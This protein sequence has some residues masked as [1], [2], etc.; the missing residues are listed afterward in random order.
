MDLKALSTAEDGRAVAELLEAF[1]DPL[2]ENLDVIAND[3]R[4]LAA[5]SP[6]AAQGVL[7]LYAAY[8]AARESAQNLA[9]KL[10]GAGGEVEQI[11]P[12]A[13]SDRRGQ[14]SDSA[15]SQLLPRART[16]RRD[17]GARGA[18]RN[19]KRCSRIWRRTSTRTRG[20]EVRIEQPAR[21]RSALRRYNPAKRILW[22]SEV[23]RRGSRNFQLAHQVGLLTQ[24]DVLDRI[25]GDPLL[26]PRSRARSRGLRS[27]TTSPARMLMP[28]DA[29]LEAR[30]G[31]ALRHR[32]ARPPLP[33]EL[34]AD[35]PPPDDAAAAR[36]GG[37]AVPHPPHRHRRQHLQALQR[38]GHPLRALQRRLPALERVRRVLT[39][40]MIRTQVS[41]LP[42]G[43]VFFESRERSGRTRR[44]P[45]APARQSAI[46]MGCDVSLRA[47]RW[48][49]RT[50]STWRTATPSCRSAHLPA[51][52]AHGLRAAGAPAD[53]ACPDGQRARRGVSFY[54]PVAECDEP[55]H[56]R[57]FG[58]SR[59]HVVPLGRPR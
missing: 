54:A 21:M 40:G 28:Y 33:R 45:R 53:A 31:R 3:V 13:I 38:V 25:A 19:T 1:G 24:G 6:A 16:R 47:A 41:Q 18:A 7:R 50:A 48:S 12:I 59:A 49:M 36:R 8:P 15:A 23:L 27:P 22:L 4:E 34:R 46:A 43:H 14:R 20:I 52:R 9:A 11:A 5:T 29:F 56:Y 35:L 30:E 51:V 39:P 42:D 55:E 26:R 58:R 2:F 17:A 37:R 57:A 32:A 44:L 10:I